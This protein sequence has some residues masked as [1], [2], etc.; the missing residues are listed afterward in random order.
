M[1]MD[2]GIYGILDCVKGYVSDEKLC[3]SDRYLD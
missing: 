3:G 1:K 2:D